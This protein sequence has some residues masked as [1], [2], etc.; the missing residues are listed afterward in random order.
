MYLKIGAYNEYADLRIKLSS[1]IILSDG[2]PDQS[3]RI[4]QVSLKSLQFDNGSQVL[5]G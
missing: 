3:L 4:L 2:A 5:R 1:L